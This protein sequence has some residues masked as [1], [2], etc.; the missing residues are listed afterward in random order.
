MSLAG[1]ALDSEWD[2]YRDRDEAILT[3]HGGYK[4]AGCLKLWTSISS[5][6]RHRAHIKN[7]G[8]VCEDEDSAR[9]LRNLHRPNLATGLARDRPVFLPGNKTQMN[10]VVLVSIDFSCSIE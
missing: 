7:R 5:L 2:D 3:E 10:L 9:E 8:T 4:C 6:N 1:P